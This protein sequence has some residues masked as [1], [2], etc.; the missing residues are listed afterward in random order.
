MTV[1]CVA[2]A[3]ALL[4][5]A[6]A[7]GPTASSA[8]RIKVD[9]RTGLFVDELGRSRIFHGVN[10]VEKLAPFYPPSGPGTP[11]DPLRSLTAADIAQ[12][13]DEWG[14][15]AVRL[16]VLW[17]ATMPDAS[18]KPNATYL[19]RMVG[20]ADALGAA[21][22]HTIVDAHQDSLAGSLC[23]EGVPE[24]AIGL[25]LAHSGFNVSDPATAFPAPKK[26]DLPIDP[27]TGHPDVRWC[28]NRT[29]FKY[30]TTTQSEAAWKGLYDAPDVRAAFATHWGA[31]AAAFNAGLP[32]SL[33]HWGAVAPPSPP[34][35]PPRGLIGYELLNEPFKR[36]GLSLSDK[37]ALGP[38]YAAAHEAIRAA[39]NETVVLWEPLVIDS[40]LGVVPFTTTDFTSGPGGAAYDDRQA[41]AY[42]LYCSSQAGTGEPDCGPLS[43]LLTDGWKWAA[44]SRKK[45]GGG[46]F[47]TEFGAVSDS[48]LSA[49]LLDAMGAEA[50]AQLQSWAYWTYKSFDDITTENKVTETFFKA[51]GTLQMNKIKRLSRTYAMAIAGT[52]SKSLFSPAAPTDEVAPSHSSYELVYRA[53]GRYL[54]TSLALY[55]SST[56]SR[57]TPLLAPARPHFST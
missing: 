29:F 44:R 45:V 46:G 37:K 23:G 34:P 38:L 33:P 7:S 20:I 41:F 14:F 1:V 52:P 19:T 21:G 56:D 10:V 43:L 24:W 9:P 48:N 47:L 18:G 54:L 40:Y 49:A 22:V 55:P 30:L 32:A 39:D 26:W 51:D 53:G 15:N 35:P 16:G 36:P 12:L 6:A 13:H 5:G 28:Q 2:A 25:A 17:S 57:L 8:G 3:L 27:A 31:V 11:E 50:D 42:H 4:G